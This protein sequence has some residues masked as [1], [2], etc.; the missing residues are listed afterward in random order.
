MASWDPCLLQNK[1]V[2]R[3]SVLIGLAV[4]LGKELAIP[5]PQKSNGEKVGLP[6]KI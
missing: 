2:G 1:S 5:D 4:E 3:G 6:V